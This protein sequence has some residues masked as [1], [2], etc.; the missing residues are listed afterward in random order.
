MPNYHI[1]L[2]P[3]ESYHLFSRAIG[4]EKLFLTDN[5]YN[6]FLQKLRQHVLP[7]SE[8][9]TYSLLPNHFH[10]L[11]RILPIEALCIEF[12]KVKKQRYDP[13]ENSITDFCY[14]EV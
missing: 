7:V 11:V 5:N 3:G 6:Y 10:L 13:K 8:I 1:P 14:R 2:Q 12:E 4:N 9:Y